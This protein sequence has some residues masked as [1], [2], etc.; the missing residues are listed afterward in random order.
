[1]C[2]LPR[3]A[4]EHLD[5]ELQHEKVRFVA[6]LYFAVYSIGANT[7]MLTYVGRMSLCTQQYR[8]V[9]VKPL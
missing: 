6:V 3:V 9:A 2:V 1:M 4:P 7:L 5:T 8:I